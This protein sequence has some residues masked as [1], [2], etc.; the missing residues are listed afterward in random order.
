MESEGGWIAS[1]TEIIS[2]CGSSS[3]ESLEESLV[4]L[5]TGRAIARPTPLALAAGEDAMVRRVS[6]DGERMTAFIVNDAESR[7]DCCLRINRPPF[8]SKLSG[9]VSELDVEESLEETVMSVMRGR[10]ARG[11]M[12]GDGTTEP[13]SETMTGEDPVDAIDAAEGDCRVISCDSC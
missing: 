1:V 2:D 7:F 3:S 8:E 11:P 12:E 13:P 9:S 5:S 6:I 4:S 10:T